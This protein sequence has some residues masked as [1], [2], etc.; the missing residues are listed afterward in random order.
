MIAS[1]FDALE[2]QRYYYLA[3]FGAVTVADMDELLEL[4][5]KGTDRMPRLCFPSKAVIIPDIMKFHLGCW[6]TKML[7]AHGYL[8]WDACPKEIEMLLENGM[9][10]QL[11]LP[12]PDS[13]HWLV[14]IAWFPS[15]EGGAGSS[16]DARLIAF[17]NVELAHEAACKAYNGDASGSNCPVPDWISKAVF[18]LRQKPAEAPL[19][20]RRLEFGRKLSDFLVRHGHINWAVHTADGDDGDLYQRLVLRRNLVE[21]LVADFIG[22]FKGDYVEAI[23]MEFCRLS[24]ETEM[25][26]R[27]ELSISADQFHGIVRGLLRYDG[28]SGLSSEDI[29]LAKTVA[30]ARLTEVRRKGDANASVFNCRPAESSL[31]YCPLNLSCFDY[32]HGPMPAH[33]G[34]DSDPASTGRIVWSKFLDY[35]IAADEV[36]S[37]T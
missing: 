17:Y 29:E 10:Q 2:E 8:N 6:T 36:P 26:H 12:S 35:V 28:D 31:L 20:G 32:A 25:S 14:R 11:L 30:A 5:K 1:P 15:I 37:S 16:S 23:E 24:R 18:K 21:E 27:G 3:P 9:F 19:P 7:D 13:F 34:Q 4:S 22:G 33:S